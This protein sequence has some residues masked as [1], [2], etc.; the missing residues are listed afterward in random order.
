MVP[1]NLY[2]LTSP[3][4]FSYDNRT[5]CTNGT[6]AIKNNTGTLWTQENENFCFA[7]WPYRYVLALLIII[8]AVIGLLLEMYEAH[9]TL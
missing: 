6:I 5:D 8:T 2:A 1:L 3:P 4:P 9:G 7:P